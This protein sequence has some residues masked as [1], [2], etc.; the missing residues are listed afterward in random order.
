[1]I[2]YWILFVFFAYFALLIGIAIVRS[3]RMRDMADY[4]LGGRRL[5]S[6]T[7]ALSAGSST[8]SAWTVL[9]L[10]ALAFTNGIIELWTIL[11]IVVAMWLAW[12]HVAKRLRRYTIATDDA[13][14]L[15]E[16]YEKRF[17]DATGML[18]TLTA[19]ITI[20]FI[21]FYVSSGL[22]GGSK[23][24]QSVFG[25]Q[26]TAGVLVTLV[27]VASYTLIGGFLAVS[28]TDVLQ[29]LLMLLGLII[30]PVTLVFVAGDA[31]A[32]AGSGT[33][34]YWNPLID[35]EG[36]FISFFII[37][38][39]VGWG[40]GALGSP[41]VLQRFMAIESESKIPGGR[42]MSTGWLL[43]VYALAVVLGVTAVPALTGREG[44]E[45]VLED[46]ERVFLVVSEVFF[47]PVVTGL[48]LTV[49][50]AAIMSTAD[51]Q[52]LL[53]SAIATDDLPV[54]KRFT[55]AQTQLARV[56]VGRVLLVLVG[57]VAALLSVFSPE[58]VANLVAYAWGGMGAAFGPLTVMAL[59]WR[60]FNVHGAAASVIAGTLAASVWGYL[61][62]GPSGLWD[63]QPAAPGSAAAVATA[64]A[65]TLLTP[66]PSSHVVE[67]FDRVTGAS[68][69]H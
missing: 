6:F 25:L 43:L 46:P 62:G 44:V 30:L 21:I 42:L 38:S 45:L 50:V 68:S 24:L 65:V 36:G 22:V 41:R 31:L 39:A 9:A 34:N 61:S 54:I 15:P 58:S 37:I 7:T 35:A 1:M 18:R 8:T 4:V 28:R 13:L 47:H 40:I 11:A 60:R 17:G 67:L 29:A 20:F 51:S 48:L 64:V 26:Y 19:A 63:V 27:A 3:R 5:S 10:P 2:D 12:T 59:Y 66:E 16:F 14:T 53:A 56:S 55:Y 23:L 52:L 69:K 57:I 33:L 32:N 49:L